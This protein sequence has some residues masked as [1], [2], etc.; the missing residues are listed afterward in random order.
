MLGRQ[1]KL[2]QV[3]FLEHLGRGRRT[4]REALDQEA[5]LPAVAPLQF[6][7]EPAELGGEG[8]VEEKHVHGRYLL[9]RVA[10]SVENRSARTGRQTS[11]A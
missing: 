4:A 2:V 1:G 5:A 3:E 11:C 10:A 6:E 8:V 7:A 9:P